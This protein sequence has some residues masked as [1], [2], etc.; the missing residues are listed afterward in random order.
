MIAVAGA[1][2][3]DHDGDG[4]PRV[5]DRREADEP[6]EVDLFA[7]GAKIGGAGFARD[8][9][10]VDLH[11]AACTVGTDDALHPLPELGALAWHEADG[12]A[13]VF[14]LPGFPVAQGTQGGLG[15]GFA[16]CDGGDHRRH[17]QGGDKEEAL[18][19]GGV[20][21]VARHPAGADPLTFPLLR[22]HDQTAGFVGDFDPG[23]FIEAKA[24]GL[25]AEHIDAHTEAFGI[26]KDIATAFDRGGFVDHPVPVAGMTTEDTIA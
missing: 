11:E 1:G 7:V 9:E 24:L 19:D 23:P 6:G 21:R 8:A 16:A 14:D 2:A 13:A 4:D 17:L 12:L 26:E 5:L 18:A 22:R 15:A 20:G 3:F 25:G 10:A